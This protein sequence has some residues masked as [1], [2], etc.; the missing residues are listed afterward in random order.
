MVLLGGQEGE[1]VHLGCQEEVEGEGVP[2]LGQEEEVGEVGHFQEEGEGGQH[3][4]QVLL[5]F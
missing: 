4:L 5:V 3:L 1:E 2:P